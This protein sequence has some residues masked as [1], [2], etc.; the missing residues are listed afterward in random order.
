MNTA[1][2]AGLALLFGALMVSP[3]AAQ[4]YGGWGWYGMGSGHALF[5]GAMMLVFWGLLIFVVV[6]LVRGL[7]GSHAPS[8]H[9]PRQTALEILEERFARGEIDK[10][11][12]LER[13][14]HL[15]E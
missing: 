9:P 15:S 6:Y 12:F 11:E 1:L 5:G 8:Q 2:R 3:A 4:G 7:A 13:K 10:E 14:K